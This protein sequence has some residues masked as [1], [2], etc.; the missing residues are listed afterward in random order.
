MV[1]RDGV[2]S[3]CLDQFGHQLRIPPNASQSANTDAVTLM[4]F[5]G[6]DFE[7]IPAIGLLDFLWGER[8]FYL[9]LSVPHHHITDLPY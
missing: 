5:L 4:W 7:V 2:D 9:G 1:W 3:L 8:R 6:V